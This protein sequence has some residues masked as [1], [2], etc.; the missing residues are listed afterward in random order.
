MSLIPRA[1]PVVPIAEVAKALESKL[2]LAAEAVCAELQFIE[3]H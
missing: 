2:K 1:I 3:T